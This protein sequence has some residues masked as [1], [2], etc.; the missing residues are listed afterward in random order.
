MPE[1][2]PEAKR[3][4]STPFADI[5]DEIPVKD[6]VEGVEDFGMV[7]ILALEYHHLPVIG[8]HHWGGRRSYEERRLAF[9]PP[10]LPARGRAS[11][12]TFLKS[13]FELR[14]SNVPQ[15]QIEPRRCYPIHP[16]SP[17]SG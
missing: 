6:L 13:S 1:R 2:F 9:P 5:A 15:Q 7:A 3:H 12:L 14:P 10:K 17:E 11:E 4:F 16:Q 8:F